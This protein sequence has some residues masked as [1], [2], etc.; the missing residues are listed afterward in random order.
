MKRFVIVFSIIVGVLNLVESIL[1]FVYSTGEAFMLGMGIGYL[2]NAVFMIGLGWFLHDLDARIENV[3]FRFNE[4][5]KKTVQDCNRVIEN[6][7]KASKA[8]M[9]KVSRDIAVAKETNQKGVRFLV[10]QNKEQAAE[11]AECKRR[12]EELTALIASKK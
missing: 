5:R 11:L 12:I 10:E 9:E 2:L 7:N 1:M 3:G 8:N 6:V 4:E